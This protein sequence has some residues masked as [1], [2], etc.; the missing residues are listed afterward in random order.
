MA[1]HRFTIR[2]D[3]RHSYQKIASI[4]AILVFFVLSAYTKNSD[5]AL[6]IKQE[7]QP[8]FDSRDIF[9]FQRILPR[10]DLMADVCNLGPTTISGNSHSNDGGQGTQPV[11][12]LTHM[13]NVTI[14]SADV[15]AGGQEPRPRS[16][17]RW[18]ATGM[19]Q[20][21]TEADGLDHR[22]DI[23]T[24]ISTKLV[25]IRIRL[26]NIELCR[27]YLQSLLAVI[28]RMTVNFTQDD[29]G[30]VLGSNQSNEVIAFAFKVVDGFT[31]DNGRS[32]PTY[33]ERISKYRFNETMLNEYRST[34]TKTSAAQAVAARSDTAGA[35]PTSA[36]PS[37]KDRPRGWSNSG[38][39]VTLK[40]L[41]KEVFSNAYTY[42]LIF[43]LGII[44]LFLRFSVR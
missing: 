4:S 18:L 43:T 10:E 32:A 7:D 15:L 21:S 37:K 11:Q 13:N 35:G 14:P 23:A 27:S 40:K 38:E 24:S 36:I 29:S 44:F 5:A 17:N 1:R 26:G 2:R 12:Y 39:T 34:L 19:D 6:I 8:H 28:N 22:T 3:R 25:D 31:L 9:L 42:I 41:I 20:V 30:A 16:G 33:T